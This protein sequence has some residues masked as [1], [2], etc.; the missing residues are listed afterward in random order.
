MNFC[1]LDDCEKY[2]KS[3]PAEVNIERLS[4]TEEE[5]E[6][7]EEQEDDIEMETESES[8]G[9]GR[10]GHFSKLLH[11][12]HDEMD[13]YDDIVVV[14]NDVDVVESGD[15]SSTNSN[16]NYGLHNTR[17]SI[18]RVEEVEEEEVVVE[19]YRKVTLKQYDE[20]DGELTAKMLDTCSPSTFTA[21]TYDGADTTD[22]GNKEEGKC[23]QEEEKYNDQSNEEGP[24]KHRTLRVP[25]PSGQKLACPAIKLC[26][27]ATPC[28]DQSPRLFAPFTYS[29]PLICPE[30]KRFKP[31]QQ[32]E[33]QKQQEQLSIGPSRGYSE[34][35]QFPQ[36]SPSSFGSPSSFLSFTPPHMCLIL[37]NNSI[38]GKSQQKQQQAS[39]G[40]SKPRKEQSP[41][42]SYPAFGSFHTPTLEHSEKLSSPYSPPFSLVS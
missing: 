16:R 39:S 38:G 1:F 4:C 6:T 20:A 23:E 32:H 12:V 30:P 27:T 25:L 35:S 8:E 36:R 21:L 9:D 29:S 26:S 19:P 3:E 17:Y 5:T 37:E 28:I 13:Q 33:K 22:V 18:D 42:L 24:L 15:N 40:S 14:D 41:L 10:N 11:N 7:E 31:L 2:S 34:H